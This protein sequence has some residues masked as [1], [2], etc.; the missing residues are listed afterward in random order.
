MGETIYLKARYRYRAHGPKYFGP[1]C[2]SGLSFKTE[3]K[4][5]PATEFELRI[6]N[7][8]LKIFIYNRTPYK[9]T[10]HPMTDPKKLER[11]KD[12]KLNPDIMSPQEE[13]QW[14]WF[15][16][17]NAAR[18]KQSREAFDQSFSSEKSQ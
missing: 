3:G 6:F 14:D 8:H 18:M 13:E 17:Q 10:L 5:A 15:D 9:V 12:S 11:E 16:K 4:I 1:I 2:L 7:F